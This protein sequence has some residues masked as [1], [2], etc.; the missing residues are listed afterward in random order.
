MEACLNGGI[1][2]FT[3]IKK[4]RGKPNTF[5]N[6]IDNK[7]DPAS[8][9]NHFQDIYKELY[10]SVPSE[11]KVLDIL[12]EVNEE[13]SERDL[14]EV[15]FVDKA[16]IKE[17]I[18]N[19][20][21]GKSD[22]ESNFASDAFINA[23][24][25]IS[26]P[27]AMLIKTFL[28]HGYIP[29]FLLICSLVPLVK[30]KLGDINSSE[31]YRA[32]AISSLFLKIF[33]WI[34][35]I[36]YGEKLKASDLQFGFSADNSTT[37]CTWIA[38]E[39]ISYFIR[40]N[41]SVY[42]C[43]LDLKKAFDKVE[44]ALLFRKLRQR[45]F[46][47]IFLRL[48]IFIYIHQSCRVKWN[49]VYSEEFEVKNGVRQG[50]VLSPTLFSLYSDNLLILLEKSGFG[51][52]VNNYYYGSSAYADDIVL[53]SPTRNGLQN[54]FSICVKYF[55]EHKITIST[56]IDVKKARQNASFSLIL[57]QQVSLRCKFL[58]C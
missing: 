20:K 36:L 41:K 29:I 10:N 2:I 37:M 55:K 13:I 21:R 15:D 40:N 48:L 46:P 30:D 42:C 26:E 6:K 56:N 52:H 18:G 9:A 23:S 8:I 19:L 49:S 35:L 33:D 25:E 32:I 16:L 12:K 17:A 3:E 31:N 51:C 24:D 54:M 57:K 58:M 28:I 14:D 5:P 1:N 43:L 11:I 39:V 4:M 38:T 34:I 44:F 50:A 7:S 45:K 53:L 22:V 47:N 27:I